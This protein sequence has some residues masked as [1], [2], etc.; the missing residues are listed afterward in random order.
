LKSIHPALV[1]EGAGFLLPFS[2]KTEY[3]RVL[4]WKRWDTSARRGPMP[5]TELNASPVM[6]KRRTLFIFYVF[7][8]FFKN[9]MQCIFYHIVPPLKS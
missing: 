2:I 7:I 6:R 4:G 1:R 9:F 5:T 8:F 3:L